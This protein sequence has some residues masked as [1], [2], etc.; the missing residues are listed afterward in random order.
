MKRQLSAREIIL[1]GLLLVL[2]LVG[3]YLLLYYMPMT[4]EQERMENQ[5]VLCEE[6]LQAAQIRLEDKRRMERELE[7]ILP[8]TPILWASPPMTTFSR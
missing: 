8:P 5:A 1:L 6:Q 3:G 7:E 4:N 2:A